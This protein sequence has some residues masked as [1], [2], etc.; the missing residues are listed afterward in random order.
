MSIIEIL[1][2]INCENSRKFYQLIFY[3]S[4]FSNVRL[5]G[6]AE[7]NQVVSLF[8]EQIQRTVASCKDRAAEYFDQEEIEIIV[9]AGNVYPS[10]VIRNSVILQESSFITEIEDQYVLDAGTAKELR[11]KEVN[12]IISFTFC[13]NASGRSRDK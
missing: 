7:A 10:R 11:I 9:D 1:K 8:K 2:E 12:E 4:F 6:S 3:Y 5:D 13:E